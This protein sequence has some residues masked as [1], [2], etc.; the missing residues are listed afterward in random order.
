MN[1]VIKLSSNLINPANSIDV[2]ERIAKEAEILKNAGNQ[3]VIVTSGA[4]MYGMK[5]L[6]LSHRPE[7][8]PQLQSCASIGQIFL[9]KRFQ[10]TFAKYNLPNS[11][12]IT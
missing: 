1:I 4:V 2:V 5:K 3:V 11:V 10:E 9:M 12:S 7:E 6:E 8:V